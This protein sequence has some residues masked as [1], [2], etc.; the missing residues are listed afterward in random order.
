MRLASTFAATEYRKFM[1]FKGMTPPNDPHCRRKVF[2]MGS[3]SGV[4]STTS[5]ITG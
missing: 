4:P 3:V 1:P 2:E 5:T